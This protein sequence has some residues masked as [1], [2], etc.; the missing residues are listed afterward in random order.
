MGIYIL[1][2]NTA[3]QCQKAGLTRNKYTISSPQFNNL[4]KQDIQAESIFNPIN[5]QMRSVSYLLNYVLL[6]TIT[7]K[8]TN[9]FDSVISYQT[10]V[11]ING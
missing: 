4:P 6:S 3:V 1:G 2:R 9:D 11:F 5:I 10:E 8:E 7:Y